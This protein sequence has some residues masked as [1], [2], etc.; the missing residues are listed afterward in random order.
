MKLFLA[1]TCYD[2]KVHAKCSE[3][4][5]K[6]CLNLIQHG[7]S[8]I[9]HYHNEL[10]IDRA[11][12]F[13]ADLFLGT[14]CSDMVFI[15]SDMYFDD[16]AILKLFKHDKDVVAGVYR[17]KKESYEFP[18]VL[19]FSHE[20]NCKEE[21][22]G[23]V[24]AKSVPT[25]LLRISRKALEKLVKH[26]DMKSD[27][28]GLYQFF[29]TGLAFTDS[30]AWYGEDNYFCRLWRDSG[31]EIFIQPDINITHLG[32]KE[33]KGNYHE[34]LLD[35]RVGQWLD[36]IDKPK[37]G[38]P[39]WS[40]DE[41][42]RFLRRFAFDS[43]SVAEVGSWKGRSTRELLK[44]CKGKV[45]AVD[46]WKGSKDFVTEVGVFAEDV[47][48]EFMQNVGIFDNLV[49]LKG[50]SVDIAKSFN[51]NKV[52]MVYIDAG[53]TYEEVKADI[54]AWLPKCK[55]YLCGHDYC[56]SEVKKAVDEKFKN[57]EIID[58]IWFVRL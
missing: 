21:A 49:V 16:D 41:E 27:D 4:I 47:Y 46:H 30:N 55:K 44:A 14:D 53:H 39:G 18:V 1:V 24:Y 38:L 2:A 56:M 7:N 25:G 32:N 11:R 22:T 45:Y 51:G 40:S 10:Y 33:F 20:N 35:R 31:G 5:L 52:D 6:N 17:L 36:D 15:D 13:C 48:A 23:L 26:Y 50:N 8:V 58:S 28:S 37:S 34:Y 19:D 3:S 43:D 57:V 29:K 42:L 9:V 54:E 12:N